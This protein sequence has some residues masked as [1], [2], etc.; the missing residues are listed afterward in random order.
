VEKSFEEF[1]CYILYSKSINRYY[2]GY[3]SDFEERLKLHNGGYFGGKSYTSRSSDW[4]LFLLIPCKTIE[5]AVF[6]ESRIKRMKS[7][8]YIEN[9]KKQPSLVEKILKEFNN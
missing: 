6:V 8:Q 5:Q 7:R 4:G 3:T 1:F 2:I 9:L